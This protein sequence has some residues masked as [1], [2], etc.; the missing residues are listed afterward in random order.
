MS[1]PAASLDAVR[2]PVRTIGR[3][4]RRRLLAAG[5]VAPLAA[6]LLFAFAAPIVWILGYGVADNELAAVWPRVSAELR[7]GA[8]ELPPDE[9]VFAALTADLRESQ[10]SRT[11]ATA[12]RRLNYALP[13]GRSLVTQTA[14]ALADR[15]EPDPG[16]G[17]RETLVALDPA[18]GERETWVALRQASGP[19]SAFFLLS[20]A[21]LRLGADGLER[22]PPEQRIYLAVLWR[23]FAVAATV[24]AAAIVLGFPVAYFLANGPPALASV[25]MVLVLLPLW[26]SLL[27]RTG[28][29][30]V[31]LQDQG[32]VNGALMALGL[33]SEPVRLLF[34]RTGLT[35]AMV[36]ISLPYLILPLYATMTT[37]RPELVKAARSLGASPAVAFWRVYLPQTLPGLAAGALLVFILSLGYYITPALVGGAG[38]QL[39][40]YFIA[41]YTTETF[42]WGMAGALAILLVAATAILYVFYARL[43]GPRGLSLG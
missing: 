39:V 33:T 28:A 32:L 34:N 29:W 9:A 15:E 42:N 37:I 35:I 16:G 38:D 8:D 40:S 5:L 27:V 19:V 21:D 41:F 30:V 2:P 18:W 17:W 4:G 36:H 31:L 24:T 3:D 11:A 22:A 25:A 12:A 43:A 1:A 7:D 23:T 6:F 26:T 20:A 13:G 10:A 14:R